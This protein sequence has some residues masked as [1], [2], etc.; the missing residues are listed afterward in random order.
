MANFMDLALA[1]ARA[2]LTTPGTMTG[3]YRGSQSAAMQGYPGAK[4]SYDA[5]MAAA[6]R[7]TPPANVRA[8]LSAEVVVHLD[9]VDMAALDKAPKQAQI[10]QLPPAPAG[11]V[12]RP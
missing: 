3:S 8:G 10:P 7:G 12:T 11:V 4:Q 5:M 2:E 1:E 6:K 9:R